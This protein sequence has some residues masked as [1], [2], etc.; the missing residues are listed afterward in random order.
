MTPIQKASD[1]LDLMFGN[2]AAHRIYFGAFW[3][4]DSG[5]NGLVDQL[6]TDDARDAESFIMRNTKPDLATYFCVNP[7]RD[8]TRRRDADTV[9][10]L[11]GAIVDIDLKGVAATR[12]EVLRYLESGA[13]LRPTCVVD[14]GHGFHC[15]FLFKE[16]LEATP[17]NK[18]RVRELNEML[19]EHFAGDVNCKDAARLLRLPFSFN[20]KFGEKLPV[21]I[22]W[23]DDRYFEP[24]DIKEW[25]REEPT[26][27]ERLAPPKDERIIE[28][29]K[30]GKAAGN[31]HAG[32]GAT[33]PFEAYGEKFKGPIDVDQ[34]LCDM[35]FH[36]AGDSGVHVT[37]LSVTAALL[38]RGVPIDEVATR[39]L[40]ATEA[41]ADAAGLKWDMPEEKA[42]LYDMCKGW[43]NKKSQEQIRA[44]IVDK[45]YNEGGDA[46]AP[47]AA[48]GVSLFDFYAYMPAHSYLFAPSGEPWPASSVDARIPPL[49]LF[50]E[51][52]DPLLDAKGNQKKQPASAWLDKH[53]PV[54][55]MTWAPGLPSLI[56]DRLVSEGGWIKRKRVA[57]FNLYRPPTIERGDPTQ[58]GPWIQHV[59]KVFGDDADHI[60]KWLAH[61]VQRPGEK[62]NHALVL[63]GAQGIG[64]DTLLEPVKRTVGP[65][66]FS[67]V[68]PQQMTGRF[69][70]FLKS[71]ILRL[72]EARDLGDAANANRFTFYDH[73]KAYTAAPP[74]VLRVDEKN[75]REH[76]IFNCCGVII[77]TNHK[78]DGLYLPPD[79]RRHFVAW[80]D[81]TKEDFT[82]AYWNGVWGWYAAG[83]D[84]HVAAYLAELD[85]SGFDPKAPPP[86]TPA[87]WAVVDA[88][89]A[90]EDAE[91]ADLLELVEKSRR[92][93]AF[94]ADHGGGRGHSRLARRPQ[95]PPGDPVSAGAMRLRPGAQRHG[96][97]RAVDRPREKAGHLRETESRAEG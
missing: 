26:K 82:P 85:I 95:E 16:P 79:D 34:R 65:W 76:A 55:Q 50:D 38:N 36:G 33:D 48:A 41:F 96:G 97:K 49:L 71:V 75:L 20:T 94:G 64:K 84:R 58:A 70:G 78:T 31:G 37:Q 29:E 44:S 52:G 1:F 40:R 80:S 15:Y 77:T 60:I 30:D 10:E 66:N 54:E 5:R 42:R 83:G 14:S 61:R 6:F 7:L 73:M 59:V 56:R 86:K 90:P 88:N 28:P 2:A 32:N 24:R 4:A 67:E 3:N 69:N 23:F 89:R 74:D 57:C 35:R 13:R 91:L 92:R 21:E 93:Y 39:V 72:N 19:I 62:I 51:N 81:L 68:S 9:S 18:A 46:S 45:Q 22:L 11:M 53:R 25:L 17:E 27:F 63:G 12:E 47:T 8:D 87:F 43:L